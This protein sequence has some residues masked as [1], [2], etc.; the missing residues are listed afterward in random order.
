MKIKNLIFDIGGV[1]VLNKKVDFSKFDNKFSLPKGKAKEIVMGC[2]SKKMT[3]KNFDEK[4]FF[5]KNF[6]N[7]LNWK[8]YQ[9]MLKEIFKNEKVNTS[10]LNW[11]EKRRKNYKIYLLTNNTAALHRLL[12]EKFKI[13]S[14][15]D[16]VFNSAEIGLAKPDLEFF[17][18]L[19]K[20]IGTSSEEC[21][22][23]DDNPKNI[24]SAENIGFRA[25]LFENN[26]KF[27]ERAKELGI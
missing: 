5:Q 14:I 2:F 16:S 23:V 8:N 25:I 3:D 6:S 15:F 18:Y 11:I 22:F 7:S 9:K 27:L 10:L 21:L 13:E 24:K 12:R 19:L 4:T 26:K 20:K 17:K 1:I